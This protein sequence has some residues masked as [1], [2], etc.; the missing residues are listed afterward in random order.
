MCKNYVLTKKENVRSMKEKFMEKIN[1]LISGYEQYNALAFID[2]YAKQ[3]KER[4]IDFN[5][6]QESGYKLSDADRKS[7]EDYM[8][9]YR[10]L[11]D[12]KKIL[13]MSK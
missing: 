6:K 9:Q 10:N 8:E 7:G 2:T 13:S 1:G 11:V 4:V 3:V 12:L 5:K